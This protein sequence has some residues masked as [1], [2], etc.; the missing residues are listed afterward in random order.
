MI[1]I[2]AEE[3][4]RVRYLMN[5]L[6]PLGGFIKEE[7]EEKMIRLYPGKLGSVVRKYCE[8]G[9]EILLVVEKVEKVAQEIT[10]HS[11]GDARQGTA[12]QT[13]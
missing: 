8:T 12:K 9:R 10:E 11:M 7:A 1:R 13:F 6:A 5:R 4:A 3:K 2:D